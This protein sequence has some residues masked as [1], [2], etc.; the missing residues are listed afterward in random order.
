MVYI[1]SGHFSFYFEHKKGDLGLG[2]IQP[3]WKEPDDERPCQLTRM[4]L[5]L[6][7]DGEPRELEHLRKTIF[8]QL[9]DLEG[10]CLL[11]LQKLKRIRVT[12]REEDGRL[13]NAKEF[14]LRQG[15]TIGFSSKRH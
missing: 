7:K 11:F 9:D 8:Q 6:L 2:M 5:Y 1:Q 4:T 3:L 14:S 15:T 13:R 12:F 10:S